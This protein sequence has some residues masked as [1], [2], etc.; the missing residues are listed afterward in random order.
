MIVSIVA[1]HIIQQGIEQS[2][3]LCGRQ[4]EFLLPNTSV[5]HLITI[6]KRSGIFSRQEVQQFSSDKLG[7][8]IRIAKIKSAVVENDIALRATINHAYSG[9]SECS[10]E[11]TTWCAGEYADA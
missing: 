1:L 11:F 3:F 4:I 6:R 7:I 9:M 5:I 10:I 2:L 8:E